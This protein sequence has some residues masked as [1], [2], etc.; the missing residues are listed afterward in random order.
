MARIVR[1]ELRRHIVI[2]DTNVL[3][4]K[5]KGPAV[6]P[7]FEK[8]WKELKKDFSLELVLPSIV[9][10]ELLFQQTTSCHKLLDKVVEETKE[11][12]SITGRPQ[13]TRLTKNKL[14]LCVEAKIDRWLRQANAAV[15][16]VPTASIDWDKVCDWAVW[17]VPPFTS[18][19]KNPDT[20]KGFRD[21]LIYETVLQFVGTNNADSDIVFVCND[22]LLRTTVAKALRLYKQFKCFESINELASYLKLSR[23]QKDSD[24]VSRIVRRAALKFF[25]AGNPEC[26]WEREHLLDKI[27]SAKAVTDTPDDGIL[28]NYSVSGLLPN[29]ALKASLGWMREGQPFLA[30]GNPEFQSVSGERTY[31]WKSEFTYFQR[32]QRAVTTLL[33]DGSRAK[34]VR[35]HIFWS[36]EVKAD[37]RFLNLTL[38][39]LV[40]AGTEFRPITDSDNKLFGVENEER[41]AATTPQV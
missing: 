37:A 25:E 34:V 26:L 10:G 32:Y 31:H 9:R 29:Y 41:A 3:W 33:G 39:K 18:D 35:F 8:T 17:R 14:T 6:D 24:F 16:P 30:L 40:T 2:V 1:E 19:P 28:P 36:A 20:E 21:T 11:I 22:F 5:D 27:L 38:E 23:E 7:E 12:A 15:V 13:S 4:C